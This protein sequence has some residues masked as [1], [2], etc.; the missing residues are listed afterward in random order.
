MHCGGCHRGY[1]VEVES[2]GNPNP[3]EYTGDIDRYINATVVKEYPPP[4]ELAHPLH[5]PSPLDNFFLQASKSLRQGNSDA[6]AMMSRKVLEV[7]VKKLNSGAKGNL[8]ERI[9]GLE[10]QGVITRDLKEWAHLIR[11]DGNT[12]AHEEEPVSLEFAKELLS[13]TEMFLMY[14]FTMPGMIQ[15]RQKSEDV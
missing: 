2:K 8:Y 3:H 13:F 1:F 9:E 7:A 15:E 14:T 4:E 11:D 10:K 5:I 6:S 12:A